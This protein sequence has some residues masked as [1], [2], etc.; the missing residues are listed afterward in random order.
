MSEHPRRRV[1][2]IR[3]AVEM[4]E[5]KTAEV[6]PRRTTSVPDSQREIHNGGLGT[7]NQLSEFTLASKRPRVSPT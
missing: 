6:V 4:S 1:E 3:S 5:Q 7:H 2:D